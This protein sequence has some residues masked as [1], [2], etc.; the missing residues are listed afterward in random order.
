MQSNLEGNRSLIWNG[1]IQSN[2]HAVDRI[3]ITHLNAISFFENYQ[4]QGLPV[5]ITGLLNTEASWNLDYLCD[6]LGDLKLPVRNNGR[7][8][9]QQ[10]KREW[11]STGSG[12]ETLTMSFLEYAELLRNGT[13]Y[14]QDLYLAKCILANTP[15][16]NAPE[17]LRAEEQLGLQMPATPLNLWVGPGGHTTFMHYD[18]MDGTLMQLYGSKRVVLFPSSQLY[19][20]YPFS[21]LNHLRRGMKIRAS[22]SQVHPD[23]PDYDAFPRFKK[24]QQYRYEVILNPGEVLF[25]PAGWSHEVYT[26]G[27]GMVCSVNRFWHVRP[28]SRSLRLWSKWRTHL[29]SLLTAPYILASLLAAIASPNRN[30]EVRK[31]LQKL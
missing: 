20:L 13:A 31:L 27:E 9:Y 26:L 7:E 30:V 25:I 4:K 24:A 16:A 3:H 28:I 12:V 11:T 23:R 1:S 15:L 19:N 14:E 17:I 2:F 10:D 8:R 21:V 6:Q 18:S 5:L 29:G 22:Y